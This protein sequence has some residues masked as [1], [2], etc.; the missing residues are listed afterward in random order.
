MPLMFILE[1][2]YSMTLLNLWYLFLVTPFMLHS[3]FDFYS[4]VLISLTT[5]I[6]WSFISLTKGIHWSFISLTTGIHWSFISL[7]TGIHW[8]FISLTTGIHWSFISLTTGIHWSFISLPVVKL[9]KDQWIPLVKLMKDQWIPVVKLMKDQWIPV[10][11]LMFIVC[12]FICR[13]W[14]HCYKFVNTHECC[15]LVPFL[16]DLSYQHWNHTC[17]K[18]LSKVC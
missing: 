16:F 12:L 2:I 7:T 3:I 6:H 11:K 10:V 17:R 15:R 5:G 8:S 14:S 9:M 1:K 4:L 18:I 13:Q